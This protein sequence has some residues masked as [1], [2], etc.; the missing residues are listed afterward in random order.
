MSD[1]ELVE[2][3][4]DGIRDPAIVDSDLIFRLLGPGSR[5]GTTRMEE[6]RDD[7]AFFS[8]SCLLVIPGL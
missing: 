7:R 4:S 6:V 2:G 8:P 3:E 1:P 5:S